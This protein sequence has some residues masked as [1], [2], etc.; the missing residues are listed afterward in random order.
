MRVKAIIVDELPKSCEECAFGHK[1]FTDDDEPCDL[2][3]NIA[4]EDNFCPLVLKEDYLTLK[5][6]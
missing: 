2:V 1:K 6:Y 3:G 5:D 4:V